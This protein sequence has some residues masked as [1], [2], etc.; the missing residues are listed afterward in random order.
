MFEPIKKLIIKS[1][2][3]EIKQLDATNIELI[4]HNVVSYIESKR[5]VHHGINKDYMPSGYTVDSFTDDS[6]IVVEYSAEKGYF[7]DQSAKGITVA[8]YAKIEKDINHAMGHKPP[9]GPDKIYLITTQEE[10]PSFRKKFNNTPLGKAHGAKTIIYDSRELAKLIYEQSVESPKNEEYY[11]QFFPTF[12]QNLDNYEYYGKVPGQCDKHISEPIIIDAINNHFL[13]GKHL[14]VLNGVSGSGKTQAVIDYI[15]SKNTD[16]ENILWISGDDWKEDTSL[17]SVKRSRGGVPINVAGSF[18]TSKT[19]LIIDSLERTI[20]IKQLS[21]LNVGFEKGGN[22]IITSQ[23]SNVGNEYYLSIPELSKETTIKILGEDS[24]SPSD[25]CNE[26]V[27]ACRFSPLILS[28]IRNLIDIEKVPRNE[29]YEE[30]LSDPKAVTGKDGLSIMGRILIKLNG[31]VLEALKKI[32]NSG[33]YQHDSDFLSYYIKF[34]NKQAL[35]KLSIL[36]PTNITGI[37]KVHDLIAKAVQDNLN[38]LDISEAIEKY[39]NKDNLEMSPSVFREIHLCY[40]QLCKENETRGNR[41]PDWVS[42]ALLQVEGEI[43]NHIYKDIYEKDILE[44]ENLAALLS[45]IDAKEIH[46]YIIEDEEERLSYYEKCADEYQKGIEKYQNDDFKAELLHHRGKALRRY[47][48]FDEALKCFNN[49]LELKP[50]WHATYGQLAIMGTQKDVPKPIKDE[51]ESAMNCLIH[52]MFE[53]FSN[54]PLR[55]S[56]GAFARLRSYHNIK[57]GIALCEEKVIALANIISISALEGLDQFYEAY[58]SF[59]SMFGYQY[60]EICVKLAETISEMFDMPPESIDEYQWVSACEALTNTSIAAK[61]SGK[62]ELSDKMSNS[63]DIFAQKIIEKG[64]LKPYDVRAIA[65]AYNMA[66]KPQLALDI[67]AKLPDENMNHW[68]L[69]RK[70]EALLAL[71]DSTALDVINE[72]LTLAIKDEKAKSN[73]ASYH[74]LVRQCYEKDGNITQALIEAKNAIDNCDEGK[75]KRYLE[76]ILLRLKSR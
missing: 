49:L 63:G 39:M 45:V 26:M 17:N 5:L 53:D 4:G 21:E 47:K 71:N 29:L 3:E 60:P 55:V 6:N 51:C 9:N 33:S 1:L 70:A 44:V 36:L 30:V 20:N 8:E 11:K 64:N 62:L 32:A 28:T 43:K 40:T 7:E 56:L 37:L 10:P 76:K 69:Y 52:S 73:L 25:M 23:L 48:K 24:L 54:V 66:N 57:K 61:R 58:V 50:N 42:Y 35:Q 41:E 31:K 74:D 59:T 46:S 2:I 22:V 67:I 12:S 16:F 75:Y 14:C 13:Q 65:K 38:T 15:H 27:E 72:A 68:I 34:L 19:L 18:N